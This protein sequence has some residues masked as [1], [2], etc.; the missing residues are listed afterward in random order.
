MAALPRCSD[1]DLLGNGER[2]VDFDAEIPDR[3]LH[4]SVAKEKL[5][6][7]EVPGSPVNQSRLGSPQR[8]RAEQRRVETDAGDPLRQQAGILGLFYMEKTK[9]TSAQ[10]L[11]LPEALT[12]VASS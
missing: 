12:P 2:I 1:V 4:F 11:P 7:A 8:M 9:N 3:A 5:N 6:R 10:P